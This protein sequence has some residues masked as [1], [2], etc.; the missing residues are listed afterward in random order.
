M[1]Q[2]GFEMKIFPG[3]EEEYKKQAME[4]KVQQIELKQEPLKQEPI[5]QEPAAGQEAQVSAAGG[6]G[7]RCAICAPFPPPG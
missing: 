5:K 4:K 1:Q 3:M 6:P 2:L 7:P